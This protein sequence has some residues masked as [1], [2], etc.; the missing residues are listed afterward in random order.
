MTITIVGLG[1][2]D[3]QHWTMAAY[4][5]LTQA[6]EIYLRT[7]YHPSVADIPCTIYSFDKLYAQATDFNKLPS[8]YDE[9]A[10]QIVTLGNRSTGVVY[11]VP[12]HPDVGEA[13]I[14]R[15]RAIASAEQVPVTVIPGISFIEPILTALKINALDNLQLADAIQIAQQ[16][17]P[18]L[19]SDKPALIARIY[20]VEIVQQLQQA[21]LNQYPAEFQV[22]LIQ[23]AGTAQQM[24][25]H[26]PLQTLAKQPNLDNVTTL[27]LPPDTNQD[28][29]VTFQQ[30]IAHLLSPQGCPWDREQTH[31]TLRPYLLEETYE[32]LETLDTN[33]TTALAEE[34]GDLLLQIALH[35]QLAIRDGEFTWGDVIGHI[36][37]KMLRRHPHVFGTVDVTGVDE[38]LTNWEN[39]KKAEKAAKGVISQQPS[40]LDGIP[41]SLPALAQAM[42]VSK[43]AVKAGFEWDNIEG[44]LAKVVEEA[45]EVATA[46]NPDHLEAEI[47]D[48]LFS[49]VNLAR[50]QKIDPETALRVTNDRFS[51]RFKLMEQLLTERNLNLAE[52]SLADKLAVW[53]EAK[54]LY[55]K[56]K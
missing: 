56:N 31:Q 41:P 28:S 19:T 51:H 33:D 53:T 20:G 36:N 32:V 11:A 45:E 22:T 14:P 47:G 7:R 4:Q 44:V 50:W 26:C 15:I 8:V 29:F 38:I 49:V 48:L 10:H 5:C 34:L 1:P 37:R 6:Q 42:M 55:R 30:T 24:I 39:I 2:G 21:L 35:T 52:L 40:A 18:P 54:L 12:G 13:T 46:T 3:S 27:Y 16:Y 17:H 43:K 9:I 23:S 25:W